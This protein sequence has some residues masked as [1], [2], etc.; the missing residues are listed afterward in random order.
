MPPTA[1]TPATRT[2]QS[3]DLPNAPPPGAGLVRAV[4]RHH[5]TAL[6]PEASDGLMNNS[7]TGVRWG[8]CCAASCGAGRGSP[9]RRG[10]RHIPATHTHTGTQASPRTSTGSL[11]LRTHACTL[12]CAHVFGCSRE[13]MWTIARG[14]NA[15]HASLLR[16]D[17]VRNYYYCHQRE[18]CGVTVARSAHNREVPCSI[19]GR[20]GKNLGGFSD[21]LTPLFI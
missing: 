20:S 5:Q 15:S 7:G 19:P 9:C 14:G 18:L 13:V 10:R 21:T 16:F 6:Q 1:A 2:G 17:S 8:W 3:A 4:N 12:F 11:M